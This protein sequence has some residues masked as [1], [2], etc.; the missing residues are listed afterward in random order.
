M[1]SFSTK[2]YFKKIYAPDLLTELY[3]QHDIIAIF[4]ITEQ[5]VRK[6]VIA[7]LNDF[8]NALPP[9]QKID[10]QKELALLASISTPHATDLF[11]SLL[12]ERK[13]EKH[14]T[15]IECTSPHDRVL[16]YYLFHK[17][18]FD[19]VIFLH[20]FY[21][22]PNYMLYES[23]EVDLVE[24]ELKVTELAKEFTRLANK[25]DRVTECHVES[26]TLNEILYVS[27]TFEGTPE[28]STKI[29]STTGDMD[30][31]K[32]IKKIE[33]VRI[34]YLPKDKEILIS[35]TGSKYEKLLF[36]DTF[37]RVV[38]GSGY[39]EKI[40]SFDLSPVKDESFDFSKTN[41]GTPLLLW[42]IKAVAFSFGNEKQKNKMKITL[43]S[44][45]QEYG[46]HPLFTCLEELQMKGQFKNYTI[47]NVTL[48]FSFTDKN[49]GD[50]AV[51]V[52]VSVSLIKSSLCPLFFYHRYTRTLL[53]Q[54]H[55]ENGF[56]EAAKKEKEDV[57]KKW[58]E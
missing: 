50:K 2:N 32:T 44:S 54:A 35:Y 30:K 49:K 22:K 43:P 7:I 33:V 13:T 46:L 56:I 11:S 31:T 48:S 36:L 51:N 25:E 12:K 40:E 1:A 52:P 5:T 53:K 6:N 15:H 34:A 58:Q 39:E 17:D 47:E 3:K 41:K 26:K 9:E 57:V 38:C 28:L 29:D 37:L 42:K 55:I 27:A 10:I 45:Q 18:L 23:K 16:Y 20:T 4:E 19:E 8:Y 24:A 14:E 21:V